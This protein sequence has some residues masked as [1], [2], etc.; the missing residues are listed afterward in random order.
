MTMIAE[1]VVHAVTRVP[2]AYFVVQTGRPLT[3]NWP[4]GRWDTAKHPPVL[5]EVL[6][7]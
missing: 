4:S 2:G 3:I 7:K 5:K 1:P 6:S